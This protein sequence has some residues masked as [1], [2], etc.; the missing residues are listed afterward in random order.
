MTDETF[1]KEFSRKVQ[2]LRNAGASVDE[3]ADLLLVSRP[4]ISRWV[5]GKNLP[6]AR[7]RKSILEK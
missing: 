4:T 3:I 7:L 2:K 5:S 6:H 1:A